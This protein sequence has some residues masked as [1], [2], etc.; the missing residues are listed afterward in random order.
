[1][2]LESMNKE[3]G[4]FRQLPGKIKSTTGT[5]FMFNDFE[6]SLKQYDEGLLLNSLSSNILTDKATVF[7]AKYEN[8][9]SHDIKDLNTSI[10]LFLKSYLIDN[11]NQNTLFKLSVCYFE[12]DDCKNAWRYYNECLKL[13]GKPITKAYSEALGKKCKN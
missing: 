2:L 13:G 1:M 9:Y 3:Y 4:S 8:N 10:D 7:K 12:K 11:K 6:N 5:G